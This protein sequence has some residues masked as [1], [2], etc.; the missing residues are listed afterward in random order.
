MLALAL[1]LLG[2]SAHAAPPEKKAP[3][4]RAPPAP[5]SVFIPV[6]EHD[7]PTGG[8]YYVPEPFYEQLYRRAGPAAEKPQGW[9][10][11]SGVYRASLSKEAMSQR[12]AV[13]ELRVSFDL[14]VFGHAVRVRIPFRRDEAKL[15]PGASLL[16]GRAIQPEWAADGSALLLDVA[17]PGQYR[18]ELLMQPA[19][20]AGAAH[21]GL[22][23]GHSALGHVA[24]GI[25]VARR[26]AAGRDDFR[27]RRRSAATSK[28]A[29]SWPIWDPP[30]D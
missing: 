17:E 18:L 2:R 27:G 30:S 12:L 1:L 15:L 29:G 19:V 11:A 4:K 16:D 7:Q 5:Y 8:K 13:E 3:E 6:D 25:D 24:P 21:V 14:H 20:R 28:P 22:R 9:L 10:I 26:R 23:P